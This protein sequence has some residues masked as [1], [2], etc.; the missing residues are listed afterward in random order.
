MIGWSHLIEPTQA[1]SIR[2]YVA[3]QAVVLRDELA[4]APAVPAA[5][6][7]AERR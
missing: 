5:P 7:A 4:A 2:A 3:R 1:E 6:N